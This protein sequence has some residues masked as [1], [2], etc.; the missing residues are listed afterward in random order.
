MKKTLLF[1]S[2]LLIV[3]LATNAQDTI[4]GYTFPNGDPENDIYPNFGL[5]NNSGYYISAEDTV[6]HP[7]TNKRD[8]TFTDGA[9]DFA[10]TAEGWDNGE[11]A[12]LWSI[13]LKAE[14]F[15]D[16]KVSSKQL[17]DA[18]MPGPR[19]WKI[20][21]RLSGEDW[22]DLDGGQISIAND[23]T[24]GA[25]GNLELPDQF[26]DPGSTSVYIRWIMTS[27]LDINGDVV[28]ATG[29][30]KID[31]VIVTGVMISG[32]EESLYNSAFRFYPNPTLNGYINLEAKD[33]ITKLRILDVNGR[34]MKQHNKPSDKLDI[35]ELS[36]GIYFLQAAFEDGEFMPPHR[37]IVQ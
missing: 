21:A 20:Q 2:M 22:I 8:I 18:E 30:S 36:E 7:N 29:I 27:N 4:T 10:A 23:W 19:D 3:V 11:M 17:S 15:K 26:D 24:A 25:V 13:K 12:K 34:L 31:D 9:T 14:G 6:A 37:L 16:L 1:L 28:E 33:E 35:S 32:I 5:E